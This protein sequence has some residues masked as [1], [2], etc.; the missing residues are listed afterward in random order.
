[1]RWYTRP[2]LVIA[3]CTSVLLFNPATQSS[4]SQI[5]PIQPDP[6]N[7]PKI[8]SIEFP[9]QIVPDG[10]AV[11]G[12]VNFEAP[13]ADIYQAEFKILKAIDPK[14]GSDSRNRSELQDITYDP[15]IKGQSKGSFPFT[16]KTKI[17]QIV[18]IA[19]TL[20]GESSGRG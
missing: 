18:T 15:R 7:A 19:I 8:I 16:I 17:E 2:A 13:K 3:S 14:D 5:E 10:K 12:K 9:A 4:L 11:Q 20:S 6:A 1:M